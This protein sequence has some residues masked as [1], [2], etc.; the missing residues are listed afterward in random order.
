MTQRF[1]LDEKIVILAQ[2]GEDDS[3]ARDSACV[4]LIDRIIDICHTVIVDA[5]LWGRYFS[6][7]G[8]FSPGGLQGGTSLLRTLTDAARTTGKIEFRPA[9]APFP[10]EVTIPQG[11]QD[12]V[13]LVRLTV[14]TGA[15]L[16]TTDE[17]LRGDLNSCGVQERYN[18]E[19]LAPDQALDRL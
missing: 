7:L 3:G 9:A 4:D 1:I 14:E 12:D 2:K 18:L 5:N 10:G 19:V 8:R 17:A 11:S 6:Q 16:V 13:P 15:T